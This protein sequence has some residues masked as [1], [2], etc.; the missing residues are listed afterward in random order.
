[1]VADSYCTVEEITHFYK[2]ETFITIFSEVCHSTQSSD[3]PVSNEPTFHAQF[4]QNWFNVVLSSSSSLPYIIVCQQNFCIK[5]PYS[6]K[7]LN[8]FRL[9]VKVVSL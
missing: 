7:N 4:V 1:M 8:I 5:Y 3:R 6:S 2:A 9:R